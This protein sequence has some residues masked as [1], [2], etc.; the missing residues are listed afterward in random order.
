MKKFAAVLLAGGRSSRMR[1]NKALI[2]YEGTPMWRFQ[3]DK[4]A[5]LDPDQLFFSVHPGM[6]FPAGPW[7]FVHDRSAGLGPLGGLEAAL[8]QTSSECLLTLAVDMPRMTV[9]LLRE[10]L[11]QSGAPGTVPL[12]DGFYCG[13]A[14]VYPVR[15][16]PLVE[17]ILAGKDRSFQRLIGEA[18]KSGML[19][20][21]EIPAS[22]AALFAN[23][24]SPEDCGDGVAVAE[25]SRLH[26]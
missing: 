19:K 4:L 2:E 14:A 10:L 13:T 15:I 6:E 18:I 7:T 11:E 24:N 3:I 26:F 21:K 17:E 25:K 20:A 12:L 9:D 5:K 16:L 8:R 22:Q 1:T 23:W